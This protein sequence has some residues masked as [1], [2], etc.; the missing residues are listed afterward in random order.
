LIHTTLCEDCRMRRC[1]NN[2]ELRVHVVYTARWAACVILALTGAPVAFAEILPDSHFKQ[3]G[4]TQADNGVPVININRP[5]KDGVSF[6]AYRTFDVGKPGVVFNNLGSPGGGAEYKQNPDYVVNPDRVGTQ[7]AG[8]VTQNPNFSGGGATLGGASARIIVTEVLGERPS[9][10]NGKIEVA[11]SRADVVIA[12]ANGMFCTD[13]GFIGTDRVVLTTGRSMLPFNAALDRV[14]VEQGEINIDGLLADDILRLD[15]IGRKLNIKGELRG[16]DV[17]LIA[18]G[19]NLVDIRQQ[20][21]TDG[22]PEI[23]P[24]YYSEPTD[25]DGIDVSTLGGISADRIRLISTDFGVGVKVAGKLEAWSGDLEITSAGRLQMEGSLKANGALVIR[26]GRHSVIAPAAPPA[27]PPQIVMV[28]PAAPALPT[29]I[30]LP[31]ALPVPQVVMAGPAAPPAPPTATASPA[32]QPVPQVVM[33]GPA[34]PPAPPTA[35]V[36][37]A[38]LP[39]PQVVMAGPAAP[40]VPPTAMALPAVL[41]VPQVAVAGLAVP[42]A[43]PTA[44]TP[45]AALPVPSV[46]TA[47]PPP[48]QSSVPF[49]PAVSDG[50][51]EGFQ[52]MEVFKTGKSGAVSPVT[53][54]VEPLPSHQQTAGPAQRV[55][56]ITP[57][58]PPKQLVSDGGSAGSQATSGGVQPEV[59]HIARYDVRPG[60]P[61]WVHWKDEADGA[62]I[63]TGGIGAN[64]SVVAGATV[65][66]GPLPVTG[67]GTGAGTLATASGSAGAQGGTPEAAAIQASSA[68]AT[69]TGSLKQE[70]FARLL[71]GYAPLVLMPILSSDLSQFMARIYEASTKATADAGKPDLFVLPK[72]APGTTIGRVDESFEAQRMA[73]ERLLPEKRRRSFDMRDFEQEHRMFSTSAANGA[74]RLA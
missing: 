34:A 60:E 15:L 38:A 8:S 14:L 41:P 2:D 12:N 26:T 59:A 54:T 20:P 29:A 42:P 32:A 61:V 9:F 4:V 11:G 13:C 43:P 48:I 23:E 44:M 28:P 39:V 40:P 74:K 68:G 49:P 19:G 25:K 51:G 55:S 62:P 64:V 1:R 17:R 30:A 67:G 69:Q 35:T 66:A 31:A 50:S 65:V 73:G 63:S 33:A 56:P 46:A 5:D 3:P 72:A 53:G 57:A 71:R 36:S 7:L 52:V 22:R 58:A 16:V 37:P 18:G 24:G 70:D 45:S 27:P 10:L 21:G 47:P 6:N